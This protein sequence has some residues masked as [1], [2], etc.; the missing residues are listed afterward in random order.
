MESGGDIYAKLRPREPTPLDEICS[1]PGEPPIK[2]MSMRQVG[3]FNPIHC[4]DCNLEVP[5]ERLA[6]TAEMVEEVAYWDWERGAI[7]TLELASGAYEGWARNRLLDPEGETNV[8]GRVLAEKLTPIRSCYLWFFQP[9]SDEEWTARTTCPV[10]GEPLEP[11]PG[12]I[13]RQLLCERDRLVLV[14]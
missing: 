6:L 5:P 4:L 7:E 14:G 9:E 3:G 1:C 8:D 12:G 11:Y 13:F 10:C 2:L